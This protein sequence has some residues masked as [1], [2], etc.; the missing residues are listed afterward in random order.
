M[1]GN[2]DY[3]VIAILQMLGVEL[4]EIFRTVAQISQ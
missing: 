1:L 2:K 4:P 3:S